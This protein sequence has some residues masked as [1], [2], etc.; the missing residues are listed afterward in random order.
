[1]RVGPK[2]ASLRADTPHSNLVEVAVPDHQVRTKSVSGPCALPERQEGVT[3]TAQVKR[4]PKPNDLR[5]LF[6]AR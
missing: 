6:P 1:M 3:M 4:F 2:E 5:R